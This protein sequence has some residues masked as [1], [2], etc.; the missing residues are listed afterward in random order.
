M[1]LALALWT[2]RPRPR[3]VT[4]FVALARVRS[5]ASEELPNPP[6]GLSEGLAP[7]TFRKL[8]PPRRKT[9]D[10][11]RGSDAHPLLL[12]DRYSVHA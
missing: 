11:R 9:L 10:L 1:L 12:H 3:R 5:S 8:R 6:D 2:C 4:D 7:R